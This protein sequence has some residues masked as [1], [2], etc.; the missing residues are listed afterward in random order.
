MEK[1]KIDLHVHS[2]ASDGSCDLLELLETAKQKGLCALCITDHFRSTTPSFFQ[3]KGLLYCLRHKLENEIPI[4]I[5][6]EIDSPF[7]HL[8]LWGNKAIKQYFNK[9]Q[10][11]EQNI[12]NIKIWTDEFISCIFREEKTKAKLNSLVI[13]NH[14][15]EL[16]VDI[17]KIKRIPKNFISVLRVTELP[18]SEEANNILS[19]FNIKFISTSDAHS[20]NKLGSSYIYL[21]KQPKTVDEL[22]F[23]LKSKKFKT[24]GE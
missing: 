12:N 20:K 1:F 14:P 7:G 15:G 17:E 24:E 9:I 18:K 19:K 10:F 16:A 2:T 22:I 23:I 3:T 8:C 13:L 5:G 21:D 4:F 11:F 6:V